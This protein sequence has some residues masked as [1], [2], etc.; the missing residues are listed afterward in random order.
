MRMVTKEEYDELMLFFEDSM[1]ALAK[2]EGKDNYYGRVAINCCFIHEISDNLKLYRAYTPLF[3][4]IITHDYLQALKDNPECF[5]TGNAMD[6]LNALYNQEIKKGYQAPEEKYIEALS[7]ETFCLLF[8]KKDGLFRDVL[9]I[10]LFRMLKESKKNSCYYDLIGGILHSLKHFSIENQSAS[11]LPNQNVS[12]FNVDQLIWPVA[13]A[14][15]LAKWRKGKWSNTYESDISYLNK[16]FTLEFFKE[17]EM[18]VAFVNTIIPKKQ[19]S[20]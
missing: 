11:V 6:V 5:G 16:R 18:N 10:D 4:N 15:F 1:A 2:H 17:D 19:K 7:E 9:R 8:C 13:H 3:W 12:L 14:F 20:A